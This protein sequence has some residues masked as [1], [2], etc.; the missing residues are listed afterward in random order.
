MSPEDNMVALV[1]AHILR[2]AAVALGRASRT[3]QVAV[4]AEAELGM[5]GWD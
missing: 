3:G 2:I 1:L 4:A 5:E